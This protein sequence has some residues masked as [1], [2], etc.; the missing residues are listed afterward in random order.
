M[1]DQKSETIIN[2][3][4]VEVQQWLPFNNDGSRRSRQ[5]Q[6]DNLSGNSMVL[7]CGPVEKVLIA[8]WAK[9]LL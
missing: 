6:Q 9:E 3:L 5:Q 8:I 2:L 1:V 7:Q 4:G